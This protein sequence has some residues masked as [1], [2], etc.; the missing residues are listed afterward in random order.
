MKVTF[1]ISDATVFGELTFGC[2]FPRFVA[3]SMEK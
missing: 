2:I 3:S 1:V